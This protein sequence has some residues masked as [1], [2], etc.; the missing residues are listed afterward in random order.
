MT[1]LKNREPMPKTVPYH[2]K[3][4]GSDPVSTPKPAIYT[5]LMGVGIAVGIALVSVM[6]VIV[7]SPLLLLGVAEL[8]C[9]TVTNWRVRWVR[10][11]KW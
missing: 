8:A 1:D 2:P 4:L 7:C 9:G 6:V 5:G 10:R 3:E 11:E